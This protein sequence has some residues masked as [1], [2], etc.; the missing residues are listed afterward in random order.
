MNILLA[1]IIKEKA[2]KQVTPII[3]KLT[4]REFFIWT[5]SLIFATECGSYLVKSILFDL[6]PEVLLGEIG[7]GIT[8]GIMIPLMYISMRE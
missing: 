1:K 2:K 5:L 3:K 4:R 8:I 6:A 7:R